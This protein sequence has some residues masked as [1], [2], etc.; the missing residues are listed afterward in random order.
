MSDQVTIAKN[1]GWMTISEVLNRLLSFFLIVA[2]ARYLGTEGLGIYSF[3]VAFIGI[4]QIFSDIGVSTYLIREVA[5]DRSKT[6]LY[7]NNIFTFKTIL[8]LAVFAV[9]IVSAFHMEKTSQV[10]GVILLAGIYLTL[11][12][13]A[14]PFRM[15]FNAYE[16]LEYYSII[17]IVE[18]VISLSLG[19]LLLVKGFQI[20]PFMT[21]F[22][23][24]YLIAYIFYF[25]IARRNFIKFKFTF[26]ST[27]WRSMLKHSYP[28][29]VTGIFMAIYYKIDTVMLT[30][31]TDYTIVGLYNAAYKITSALHFIPFVLIGSTFPAMSK[32][33]MSS[34]EKLEKLYAKTISYLLILGVPL[35]IGTIILSQR[36][37]FFVYKDEFLL[38]SGA[39]MILILAEVALFLSYI[40]GYMLNAIHKELTFSIVTGLWAFLNILLNYFLI[41]RFQHYGA[42]V[43]TMLTEFGV[44]ITIYIILRKK[45]FDVNI[46]RLLI[47]PAIAGVVMAIL[48]LV[49]KSAHLLFVIPI[50]I[51]IYFIMLW[52][53]KGIGQ[54]EIGIAKQ[55]LN[56][57]GLMK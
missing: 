11:N 43:A 4:F 54:E 34:R 8:S 57:L 24:S 51:I 27:F 35:A 13:I 23:I 32:Y 16:Q 19:V 30:Y 45:G 7:F 39:L 3:A 1:T 52:V 10:F 50:G 42:A 26:N 22:V 18:R 49:I 41:L 29:W 12:D 21:V 36:I 53:L 14:N 6:E 46:L 37:I 9:A 20:T 17:N 15:L 25:M 31:L 56:K 38:A 40:S 47:K 48:I 55:L 5:K 2:M 33:F 28:F 44:F